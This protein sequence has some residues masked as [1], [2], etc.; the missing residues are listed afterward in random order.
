MIR[1]GTSG[2][3]GLMGEEF[4]FHNVR[5]VVQAI[6]NDLRRKFD[7]RPVSV[8]VGYDTRFLSERFANEAAKI[9]SMNGVRVFLAD[10]DAPSQALAYQIIKRGCQGGIN[11][12]ASFNPP[13]WNGLKFNVETGAPAL[14]GVTDAI[15]EEVRRLMPSFSAPP[16]YSPKEAVTLID[17]QSD[18]L[19]YLQ[20]KIDFDVMRDA[21][22][23]VGV[24]LLYGTSREYLDEILEEND[25]AV[26]EIHGYI[27]P[28]FG[29]VSPSCT[30]DN[31]A[32]L[33]AHVVSK[34]CRLGVA[35][36]AD[37]D[38]FG[39]V[40]E[41]GAFVHP[42]LIL[43]MLL[44]YLVRI[45]GWRGGVAR[46]ISTTH[47]LDRI[48]R[49]Y[50]LPLLK[51]KVGFKYMADLFLK[52]DIM[53]G[54]EES[55]CIAVK[56]HLPEKDGIFAGLLVAEMIAATGQS[57]GELQ[58]ALFKEYGKLV[59]GER[60]LTLTPE[61]AKKLQSLAESPPSKLGRREVTSV[62][63]I[64]G[65]KLDMEGDRWV[66]LRLSGTMPIIRCNAEAETRRELDDLLKLGIEA[67]R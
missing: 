42:N 40:D 25:V 6:A 39:V 5:V 24:D 23:K 33:K 10:R 55:A 62:E 8:V 12:T 58:S 65:I 63:T 56:D 16:F 60:T 15:E 59:A 54:G 48:A 64:D 49:K 57:L 61:R 2:W 47:L 29:G 66:L 51:T 35:T 26:E 37:G 21:G 27:D 32:E 50:G 53:F 1:F 14:P 22:L 28:Y 34:G 20:D 52:G 43:S 38:R 31:L 9:L 30:E 4:T 41:K 46:S 36:D 44:D 7:G 45:K 3:R 11:F 67:V 17:L 19:A 18:Y 13:R